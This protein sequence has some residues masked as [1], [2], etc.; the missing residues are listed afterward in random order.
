MKRSGQKKFIPLDAEQNQ[1]AIGYWPS[2]EYIRSRCAMGSQRAGIGVIG[3][4]NRSPG[5]DLIIQLVDEDDPR[6]LWIASWGGANTLSQ[7]IWQV[8]QER[9]PEQ[10]SKFL[11]KLRVYT[12]TDQDMVYGMRMNRSYSSHQWLRREFAR[13]L[14]FI[15]DE[16]A[17]LSQ[18]E[19]GKNHWDDYAKMIQGHGELGKAYPTFKWGVEGD[20]PSWLNILPNGLH[21]PDD[22]QQVGWAGCFKRDM[23]PDSLTVAWT[24]WRIPQKDISREYE[25]R[26]Y[27]DTFRDFSARIEWAEKGKG[28]RNPVVDINGTRGRTPIHVTASKGE[29]VVIDASSS[30]DPDGDALDFKWWIQR[31]AGN[32]PQH[33]QLNI[34]EAKATLTIPSD[35]PCEIH[36]VCEVR[37]HGHIPLVGYRRIVI[38]N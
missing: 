3:K 6:P 7:A 37:D 28:N 2:A 5:S 20:T 16:S 38:K 32:C 35:T 12:I 26:F 13:D 30:Y 10:L 27:E 17:W 9:T 31:D 29:T 11:K 33:V 21:D 19:L 24:N 25:L 8:K 34:Q 14:L 4:A 1:Q 36:V 15:W 22:P 23:C 18:N